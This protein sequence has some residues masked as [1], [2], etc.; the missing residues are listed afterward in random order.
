MSDLLASGV[1]GEGLR[2]TVAAAAFVFGFRHGI[3]W[4]HIAAITD[5]TGSQESTGRSMFLATLY[6]LGHALVVFLIGSAAIV[7]GKG[8]PP[9]VDAVMGPFVGATL[10]L[11]GIYVFYALIRYR[12]EFRM[13]SRWMLVFA[14]VR[15]GF[16]FL[17]E[18][19]VGRGEQVVI[20]HAHDHG[21]GEDHHRE[22]APVVGSHSHEALL[23]SS[24]SAGDTHAHPHHH[25]IPLQ[26]DPF[27]NYGR[28][29]AF[30]VGMIHGVGAE[31]PTQVVLFVSV[32]GIG[33]RGAGMALL[34][35]FLAGLLGSNTA[36]AFASAFGFLRA[37]RSRVLYTALAV[38]AGTF[39]LV[40]GFLFLTGKESALPGL[41]GG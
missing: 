25:V 1:P 9:G 13:R 22:A 14:G 24:E 18:R 27:M 8:L 12:G 38:V 29:T 41:F 39:S 17:R 26:G 40:V 15:R 20:E 6:A 5:I 36:V 35:A 32:A 21:A 3:D 33:G 10:I 30:A 4:D 19:W 2:L 28:A 11:L 16:R 37:V 23:V 34:L 31:T 7:A